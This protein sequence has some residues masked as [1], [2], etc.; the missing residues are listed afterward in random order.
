MSQTEDSKQFVKEIQGVKISFTLHG[1]Q[2]V[3]TLTNRN[4]KRVF[5]EV[6]RPDTPNTPAKYKLPPD[7]CRLEPGESKEI[8]TQKVRDSDWWKIKCNDQP[9]EIEIAELRAGTAGQSSAVQPPHEKKKT[10]SRHEVNKA[11]LNR[12]RGGA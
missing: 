1:E 2:G 12:Q 3:L 9:C 10:E 6:F 4:D 5:V 7:N 11:R 8:S